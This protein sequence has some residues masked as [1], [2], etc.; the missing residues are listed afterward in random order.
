MASPFKITNAD[1]DQ[2]IETLSQTE[3]AEE[4]IKMWEQMREGR[5]HKAA[6]MRQWRADGDYR[7]MLVMTSSEERAGIFAE[8]ADRLTD[9]EAA[10]LLTDF[11]SVTEAWSGDEKLRETMYGLLARVAPLVVPGDDGRPLPE[12]DVYTIYRGN[13]GETPGPYTSSWSLD[14]KIAERFANMA[15]SPRGMF[16]G[17]HRPD[18]NPTVWSAQVS[19]EQILGYFDDRAEQEIVVRGTDLRDLQ[20]IASA[21]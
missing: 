15:M 10:V 12:R 9:E 18:G 13:L 3:G 4:Q 5:A 21:R 17:M 14:P 2:A 1:I 20:K 7:Q 19:R 16:L 8:I 11:W 6:L